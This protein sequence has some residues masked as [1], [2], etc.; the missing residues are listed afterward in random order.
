MADPLPV[1][2]LPPDLMRR[3]LAHAP[4]DDPRVVVG[5][6]VGL[7]CAVVDAG[8]GN[9][10]VYKSDPI[11]FAAE[12]I[13]EYLVRINTNDIATTGAV[14]RWLLIT[15]LLPEGR[16]T[17]E[18]AETLLEG[19]YTACREA[20][21]AVLGGHSEVTYGL[22][23][24]IAVGTLVGEVGRESLVQPSGA[25]PG[26]R[27]LV[28][29]GVPIETTAIL[30]NEFPERL[31]GVLSPAELQEARDYLAD[32]GLD[33]LRDAQ[34]ALGAGR[35]TA[36]H[37]PTEGGL[38]TALWELAEA[39]GRALEVDLTRVPVPS[40]A[41][42]A[43]EAFGLDPLATIASGSLLLTVAAE[44]VPAVI[45]ALAE[46]GIPAADIGQ[47]AEGPWQVRGPDG[48]KIPQPER[49]EIGKVYET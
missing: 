16:T 19:I 44:D 38:V 7:D 42:R 28:T 31:A 34:M 10:L 3:V 26:N 13:G 17:A 46:S 25:C 39:S 14:P 11:T 20:G 24:P 21:I 36:M 9:L 43:C 5:P 29:K 40:L 27:L 15:L 12:A 22:D 32:P 49:D 18:G 8:G 4:C 6:G 48:R 45:A 37:D 2:K 33:V 35:V 41:A 1:G 23:R 47:V 30:A